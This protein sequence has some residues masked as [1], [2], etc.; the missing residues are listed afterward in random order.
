M[1]NYQNSR[2]F[3]IRSHQTD[4]IFIGSTVSAL[5]TRLSGYRKDYRYNTSYIPNILR[6]ILN[7]NDA[8]IELIEDYPCNSKEQ[9]NRRENEIRRAYYNQQ[10]KAEEEFNR[11]YNDAIDALEIDTDIETKCLVIDE[12]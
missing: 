9:L 3:C 7:Y 5:S 10:Q 2:I 4:D 12:P 6:N 8:Y 1:P 11:L